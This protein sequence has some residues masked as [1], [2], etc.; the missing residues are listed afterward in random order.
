V[1]VT[2]YHFSA[3]VLFLLVATARFW[4]PH[5]NEWLVAVG[6]V[7]LVAIVHEALSWA[8]NRLLPLGAPATQ[9][10]GGGAAPAKARRLFPSGI[11]QTGSA[12]ENRPGFWLVLLIEALAATLLSRVLA[13]LGL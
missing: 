10:S 4:G 2:R 9:P 5:L 1:K 7:V 13:A 11:R 12:E 8:L 3:I 6:A